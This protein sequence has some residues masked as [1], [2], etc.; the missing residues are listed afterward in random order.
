MKSQLSPGVVIGAIAAVIALAGC[1][2][3]MVG[4]SSG[5]AGSLEGTQPP[6]MP[7]DAQKEFQQRMGGARTGPGR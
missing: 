7:A 4:R 5:G 1:V 2:Y 3:W 6:G